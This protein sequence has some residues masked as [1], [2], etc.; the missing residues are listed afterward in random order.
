MPRTSN[1]GGRSRSQAARLAAGRPP[2]GEAPGERRRHHNRAARGRGAEWGPAEPEGGCQPRTAAGPQVPSGSCSPGAARRTLHF[3]V[4]EPAATQ[5]VAPGRERAAAAQDD[6]VHVGGS[7]RTA[8]G[9]GGC[10]RVRGVLSSAASS[11]ATSP[12][13]AFVHDSTV[14]VKG[15]AFCVPVSD[16]GSRRFV[17]LCAPDGC[18]PLFQM[19]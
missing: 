18:L 5:D 13:K 19:L 9:R 17:P 14:L 10:G 8:P 15:G 3:P 16:M 7:R 4:R 6:R 11:A 12:A 1:K 2:R